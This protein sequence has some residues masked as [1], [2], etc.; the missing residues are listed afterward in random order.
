MGICELLGFLLHPLIS[1]A[2]ILILTR[3]FGGNTVV[4]LLV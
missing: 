3:H 4:Q 2:V 1:A